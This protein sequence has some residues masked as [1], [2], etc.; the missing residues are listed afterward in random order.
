MRSP[1]TLKND[2]ILIIDDNPSIH[3]DIRKILGAPVEKNEAFN[4]NKSLLFGEAVTE[5]EQPDEFEI[6]SAYQGQEGLDKVL[7]ASE[8]GRPYALVFVDV[9]MPPGW[10]GIETINRIWERHPDLQAVICTAY[11][12]YSWTEMI[13]MIGKSDNLVIL[14]KPF[15]NIE[16]IQLAHALTEKWLLGHQARNRMHD[17]D[18]AV[19]QR[20]REL[21]ET[22][23]QLKR[24]MA[25]RSLAEKALRLSE[26]R[27]SKAFKASPIPLAIQSLRLDTFVD[28]NEGFQVLTGYDRAELVGY[29]AQQL[30]LW[31]DPAESRL[32]LQKLLQQAPVR[33]Q[34]RHLQTKCGTVKNILLSAELLELDSEPLLLIIV[35]DVTEQLTL[36]NQLRQAQKM[37]AVGQ[38]AAGVAHDFNNILTV[39]QGYTSLM[40]SE[41]ASKLDDRKP[42][43]TISAAAEKA[44]NLVRQLLAFSRKQFVRLKP[45]NMGS[46]LLSI[47]N[48][49]PRL[50]PENIVITITRA[51]KLPQI[52]ADA[53]M[54]EQMLVNLA[55]N[56]RDAMPEGGRFTIGVEA[57]EVGA[58]Q[59]ANYQDARPGRFLCISVADTGCG[60]TAEVMSHIFEPFFTTKPV[61]KGTGLGLATVYGI[62]KQHNAWIEV[63]SEPGRG[64]CF[65]IFLPTCSGEAKAES[66]PAAPK[67]AHHGNET[68]LVVE[69]EAAVRDFVVEVLRSHGY[70]TLI[71]DSGPQ[72]LERWGQHNGKIHLLLTDMVMPGGMTGREVGERLLAKDPALKIIYSSGYSPGLDENDLSKFRGKTFLPKPYNMDELLEKLRECLDAAGE[73]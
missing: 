66:S 47:S 65:R 5:S 26:E 50:L 31:T 28:A 12:D 33:N 53:G 56:A 11:S 34:P 13:R 58:A 9:R 4:A 70:H 14:K 41:K 73:N 23:N 43:E 32:L 69:D 55:V 48:L 35:Q 19:S 16:V 36:E 62:V 60:M 37:E 20:T 49:L 63:Q 61:G 39:I 71:A 52:N 51:S 57:V 59:A 64:S 8:A 18:Q 21:Q 6:D 44:G 15:D 68:I 2:R 1:A 27:F 3:E 46:V 17:L 40:L 10:D 45:M 38:L 72:A 67:P 29:T 42:I 54:M 30:N 25:E 22:N 24:E 7:Q